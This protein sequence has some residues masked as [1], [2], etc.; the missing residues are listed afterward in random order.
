MHGRHLISRED[1]FLISRCQTCSAVFLAGVKV[2]KNYFR[3]YYQLGYYDQ[4]GIN[5]NSLLAKFLAFLSDISIGRKEGLITE[6]V[7]HRASKLFILDIGCGSGNFLAG[8]NSTKFDRFGTEINREG[9]QLGRE[10]GLKIF[11]GNLTNIDFGKKKFDVISLWHVLE[12]VE[13]PTILF[14]QISKLLK[15]KGILILQVPNTDS[16]GFRFGQKYWFHLDSPRHL[17]L[18]NPKSVAVLCHRTGFKIKRTIN[19][20]YDYPLDLFWSVRKSLVRFLVVPLYPLLKVSS[21]EHLTYICQR[22]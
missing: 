8:L 7:D 22:V 21:R 16:L 20:F 17:I 3:K 2:D 14:K 4:K 9:Y 11:L 13:E 10:R 18:Y 15:P 1:K 6:S 12:H 19:E 5:S